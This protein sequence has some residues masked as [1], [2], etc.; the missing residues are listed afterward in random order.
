MAVSKQAR[1]FRIFYYKVHSYVTE[2]FATKAR[3][4]RYLLRSKGRENSFAV[5]KP[6]DMGEH[7]KKN[8]ICFRETPTC[9]ICSYLGICFCS[10]PRREHW[11]TE[12]FGLLWSF[13]NTSHLTG[14]KKNQTNSQNYLLSLE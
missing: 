4:S 2:P 1:L 14:I 9:L 11:L 8:Y 3:D 7:Q 12:A 10:L 5:K 6:T 13:L